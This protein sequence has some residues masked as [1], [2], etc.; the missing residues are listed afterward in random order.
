M[1]HKQPSTRPAEIRELHFQH[2]STLAINRLPSELLYR[3]FAAYADSVR[4]H[5]Q[6][7]LEFGWRVTLLHVC[8]WWRQVAMSF[9]LLWNRIIVTNPEFVEFAMSLAGD[10]PLVVESNLD[11]FER[12]Y[13]DSHEMVFTQFHRV[14]QAT[15]RINP[16]IATLLQVCGLPSEAPSLERLIMGVTG[17]VH[18][19]PSFP[20]VSLPRLGEL[21]LYG[22]TTNILTSLTRPTLTSL[23]LEKALPPIEI[24]DLVKVLDG[25]PFLRKLILD[26]C[27]ND[28]TVISL[29]PSRAVTLPLLQE[30]EI[31]ERGNGVTLYLLLKGLHSQP[32]VVRLI[33]SGDIL[34]GNED[35]LVFVLQAF[36]EKIMPSSTE[37]PMTRP[38]SIRFYGDSLSLHIE[39]W[40]TTRSLDSVNTTQADVVLGLPFTTSRIQ[41]GRRF[42]ATVLSG[43]D[44]A[45]LCTLNVDY[46]LGCPLWNHDSSWIARMANLRELSLCSET[47]GDFLRTIQDTRNFPNLQVLK[48]IDCDF[49]SRPE[50]HG[51]RTLFSVAKRFLQERHLKHVTIISPANLSANERDAFLSTGIAEEIEIVGEPIVRHMD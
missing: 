38:R 16:A 14:R 6:E 17:G 37:R 22:A 11:R 29:Q 26:K 32:P 36:R 30:L 27:T 13:L 20:S 45:E 2:N 43:V 44:L 5:N 33:A 41:A 7:R 39:L 46:G 18:V 12:Q 10:T 28:S 3:I 9:P 40:T 48:L 31:V 34:G 25:L 1:S 49:G 50:G 23:S 8:R 51:G 19:I 24:H 35:P 47:C 4:E 42:M 15:F 21:E